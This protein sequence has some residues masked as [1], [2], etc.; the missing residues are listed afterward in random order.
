MPTILRL[1]GL[2]FHFYSDEGTEPAHIHVDAGDGECKFWLDP[3]GLAS[4][5]GMSVSE[6]RKAERIVFEYK[7][8]F[9]EKY[10][11]FHGR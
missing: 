9:L 11:E 8:L 5:R 10:H 7:Q 2:R 3:I 1:L 4:Q 6:L